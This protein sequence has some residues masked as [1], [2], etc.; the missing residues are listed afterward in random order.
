MSSSVASERPAIS[1]RG[2]DPLDAAATF[3]FCAVAAGQSAFFVYIVGFY[4]PSVASGDY[5]LWARN[6]MLG[7]GYVAGDETGNALF[8]SHVML[9][10]LLTFGGLVQLIP[11]VRR[12]APVL[13]RWIGRTY[14]VAALA[15]AIGGTVL[16]WLRHGPDSNLVNDVGITGNAAAILICAALA[17]RAAMRRDFATHQ[18]WATRLFLVVSGVWFLRVGMMAWGIAGQGRGMETFFNVWVFGSFL[19]PLALYEVY[20][21]ARVGSAGARAGAAAMLITTGIIILGGASA[22]AAFLWLPLLA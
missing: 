10:A 1:R 2:F 12:R 14:M 17:W 21:R 8:A 18:A 15:A 4:G 20:R 13:H 16:V 22:A 19:V 9:A 11:A 7:H 6:K 5:A 3:W